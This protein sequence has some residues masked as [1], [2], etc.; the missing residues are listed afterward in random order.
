MITAT[1]T[2]SFREFVQREAKELKLLTSDLK[3]YE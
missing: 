3:I 1:K 2:D